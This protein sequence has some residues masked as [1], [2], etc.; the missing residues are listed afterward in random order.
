MPIPSY[1]LAASLFDGVK[2][3]RPVIFSV[4]DNNVS[5]EVY[6]DDAV[7]PRTALVV[8]LDILFLT[9][10]GSTEVCE[11]VVDLLEREISSGKEWDY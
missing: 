1:S 8:L 5:G 10:E 3:S 6:V 7:N 2:N 9:G 11:D 4:L